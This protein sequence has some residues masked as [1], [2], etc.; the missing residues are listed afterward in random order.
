MMDMV[1]VC[2]VYLG[3]FGLMYDSLNVLTGM[4]FLK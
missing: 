4:G 3:A 1:Y 2:V